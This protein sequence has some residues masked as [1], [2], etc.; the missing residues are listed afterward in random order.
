[1]APDSIVR[2]RVFLDINVGTEP[3]GRLVIELFVDRAPKACEKCVPSVVFRRR[4]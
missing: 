3:A 2:P 1:M 4:R